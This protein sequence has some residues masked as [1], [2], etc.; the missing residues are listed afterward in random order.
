[1]PLR[2]SLAW[3]AAVALAL[4]LP[5][6][7][8]YAIWPTSIE[9]DCA[10]RVW[11]A[12]VTQTPFAVLPVPFDVSASRCSDAVPIEAL[13]GKV[14][15]RGPYGMPVAEGHV[16]GSQISHPGVPGE[17]FVAVLAVLAGAGLVS[18]PFGVVLLQRH[19]RAMRPAA[20]A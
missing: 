12:V 4:V 7:V 5:V 14:V 6:A 18:L 10:K 13:G 3:A 1:M 2:F 8:P 15:L 11:T 17:A 9:G 16:Q 19:F 20:V